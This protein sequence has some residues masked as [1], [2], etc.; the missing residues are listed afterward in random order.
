MI[1]TT[2]CGLLLA[3]LVMTGC[4]QEPSSR[5]VPSDPVALTRD[6]RDRSSPVVSG[7]LFGEQVLD[8]RPVDPFADREAKA[9]VLVFVCTDCPIANRYA[10]E[11]RRL[12]E[13]F[14]EKSVTFWLVYA[15]DTETPGEIRQHLE[16]YEQ[17]IPA[18]R[19]PGHQLVKFCQVSRT[20]EAVVYSSGHKRQYRGRIDDRFT[21]Y[22][23]SREFASQHD[24][25]TAI[26]AVLA[27]QSVPV[28]ETAAIGCD[29]PGIEE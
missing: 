14:R 4:G 11:L 20:P 13:A 26:E 1:F 16:E 9:I 3:G 19:D 23:K 29:I 5:A 15:D 24:L 27:G 8:G 17:T 2:R 25:Q 22:G 28:P 6:G 18:L 10:P 12:Y 21:D 7:S